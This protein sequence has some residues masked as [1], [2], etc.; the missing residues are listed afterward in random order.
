MEDL[1]V[2]LSFLRINQLFAF[3]FRDGVQNVPGGGHQDELF[4]LMT[5]SAFLGSQTRAFRPCCWPFGRLRAHSSLQPLQK[6]AP[7][8]PQIAQRKQ[9][10][11]VARVLGQPAVL[12]LGVAELPLDHT[13]WV[14]HLGMMLALV[15]SSF[16]RMAPIGVLLTSALRL[17]GIMAMC[18]FTLGCWASISSRFSTPR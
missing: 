16:S 6:T 4:H 3:R 18:Q 13:E 12:D 9:R 15:F 2:K 5:N 11:Q 17:P 7:S 14:F 8:H 10:H 1:W